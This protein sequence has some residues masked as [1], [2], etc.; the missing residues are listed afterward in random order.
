MQFLTTDTKSYS[1]NLTKMTN[2]GSPMSYIWKVLVLTISVF[3]GFTFLT[4]CDA[5]SI[6]GKWKGVS[7]KNYYSPEYAKQVGRTMDEKLAKDVGNSEII[8]NA[9]HSFIMNISS[10]NSSDIIVMKGVWEVTNDQL[11]FTLEPQ[12][13]PQKKTTTATYSIHGDI[14]ETTAIIPP[15]ARIIKS[16]AVLSRL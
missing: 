16:V 10:P 15:P 11:K 3:M 12:Y 7:V 4:S 8:Y 14:M 9:D 1:I 6:V 13:N 2:T 5:Q